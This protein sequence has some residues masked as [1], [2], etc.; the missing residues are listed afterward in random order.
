MEHFLLNYLRQSLR[1]RTIRLQEGISF[2]EVFTSGGERVFPD[3]YIGLERRKLDSLQEFAKEFGDIGSFT[4]VR[5][6]IKK[7]FGE[8]ATFQTLL[9][10][11]DPKEQADKDT[12]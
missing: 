1:R 2:A 6:W 5:P 11:I 9:D 3:A 10:L 7:R 12:T 8:D 4:D